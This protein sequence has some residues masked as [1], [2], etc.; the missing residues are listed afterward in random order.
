MRCSTPWVSSWPY[1]LIVDLGEKVSRVTNT[2]ALSLVTKK[3][4][5]TWSLSVCTTK[6]N[7]S[8]G[9]I[10]IESLQ[11][12]LLKACYVPA[13]SAGLNR[14]LFLLWLLTVLMKQTRQVVRTV[15]QSILLRCLWVEVPDSN[16][17]TSLLG[18]AISNCKLLTNMIKVPYREGTC[19]FLGIF[20]I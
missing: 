20:D 17:H 13:T 9:S 7:T 11:N 15:K 2:L 8:G 18:D 4:L 12:R 19:D 3:V 10:D 5:I 14:P 1:S 16:K 6:I